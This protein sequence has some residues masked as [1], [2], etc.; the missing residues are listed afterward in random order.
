[1]NGTGLGAE[2][3]AACE[4]GSERRACQLLEEP[5][6]F[7]VDYTDVYGN[8]PLWYACQR[9][10]DKVV[11]LLLDKGASLNCK[12]QLGRTPLAMACFEGKN[13]CARELVENGARTDILDMCKNTLLH[14][15]CSGNCTAIIPFLPD[16]DN[17]LRMNNINGMTPLEMCKICNSINMLMHLLEFK[18]VLT[19]ISI[20]EGTCP[21]SI[22]NY[23]IAEVLLPMGRWQSQC[24]RAKTTNEQSPYLFAGRYFQCRTIRFL[25][26]WVHPAE[27]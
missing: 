19:N 27:K 15:A 7:Y 5:V 14:L 4:K 20:P 8:T 17:N 25:S 1:M 3:T 10:L 24:N 22:C 11:R 13:Q 6:Y 18:V 16:V 21:F 23:P 26:S 9:G 2:V 12:G